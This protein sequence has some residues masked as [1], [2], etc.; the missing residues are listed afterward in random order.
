M[1]VHI[2]ITGSGGLSREI[3]EQLR[4]AV[5]DGRLRPGERLPATRELACDLDVSRTTVTVAY[6]RLAGEGFVTARVG[7]GTFVSARAAP[8]ATERGDGGVAGVLEPRSVWDPIFVPSP[9]ARP[10]RF[11]FR[12]GLPDASL[13]P[14]TTWRRLM[15][16]QLRSEEKTGNGVYAHPA[17]DP[18][19]RAA[20]ARHVGLARGVKASPDDV[21]VT[22]GTQQAVDLI[23]RVLLAPGD[24]VAVEDPGYPPPR[25]LLR[26]LGMRV[27]GVP[28]DEEGVVVDEVPSAARLAYVTPSHQYPLGVA[29]SLPRRLSLLSWA[30][31]NEAAIIEDDY[32]SEFRLG[33]PPIDPLAT[34]DQSGRVVYVGSFSKTM[35]PTLRLGFVIAPPSLREALYKAKWVADWHTATLPQATLARFIEDGAFA[36]HIR[37]LNRVY[38]ARHEQIV[39]LLRRDFDEHLEVI[40]AAA[41]L[42]VTAFARTLSSEG[43]RAVA[44]RASEAGVEVQRLSLF[45]AGES[46][47]AGLVLGYGAIST[48]DIEEGLARLKSCFARELEARVTGDRGAPS[49]RPPHCVPDSRIPLAGH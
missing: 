17:G 32:D 9:F 28:V 43:I 39:D 46:A 19:L 6:H 2:D 15:G 11:D 10:A 7:A 44:V 45:R 29:M 1:Q 5:L 26:S 30:E 27:V 42:H 16:R 36:R 20:I 31:E 21:I 3:Y 38:R 12:T 41:G 47:A 18:A 34:L 14:Y 24:P 13:F 48:E 40:P 37:R 49:S 4:D 22:N 25:Q 8:P 35:S 33:G 23:A